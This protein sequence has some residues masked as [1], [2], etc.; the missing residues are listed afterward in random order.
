MDKEKIKSFLINRFL[1]AEKN[2]YICLDTDNYAITKSAVIGTLNAE[3]KVDKA[4]GKTAIENTFIRP[5]SNKKVYAP[6]KAK[7]VSDKGLYHINLWKPSEIKPSSPEEG[8]FFFDFLEK[9]LGTPEKANFVLNF[10]AYR[11]QNLSSKVP[12]ALYLYGSQGQ[13]KSMFA[14]IITK[15]FG[16]SAV[17]RVGKTSDIH[18]KGSVNNWGRTFLIGEEID[19]PK[20]STFYSELKSFTGMST[21]EA[22]DNLYIGMGD[23]VKRS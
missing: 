6:N 10:I 9:C 23:K 5:W 4:T 1:E 22:D 21:V 12:Q 17:K 13:G 20:D 3:F 15:V 14:E 19:I 18:S 2:H 7:V 11:Y 8:L 16:A